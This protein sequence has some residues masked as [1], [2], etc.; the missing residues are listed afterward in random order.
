MG[1][2]VEWQPVSPDAPWYDAAQTAHI[3]HN[4]TAIG[5]AGMADRMFLKKIADGDAFIFELDAAF[6][7]S[8]KKPLVRYQVASK[9]PAIER[10]VSVLAPLSLTVAHIQQLICDTSDTIKTVE[11]VDMFQKKEWK[12]ERALTFRYR[13]QDKTKTMTKAEAEK[14]SAQVIKEIESAGGSIR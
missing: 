8:Y 3:M 2:K 7:E 14:I 13:L 10:D 12:S 4:G 11:L 1:L 9:F 5:M 6:L